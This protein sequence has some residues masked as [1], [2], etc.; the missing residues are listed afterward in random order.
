MA[1]KLIIVISDMDDP[2]R[3]EISVLDSPQRA[4]RMVEALLEAGFEQERIRIF[5]GGEMEMQVRHRPV[6]ALTGAD[7]SIGGEAST[8]GNALKATGPA[9][10]QP[11]GRDREEVATESRAELEEAV[12]VPYVKDGVRFSSLFRPA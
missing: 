5:S 11:D 1:D 7:F 8:N 3:G 12:V 6:V 4:A 9:G 2:K 10:E